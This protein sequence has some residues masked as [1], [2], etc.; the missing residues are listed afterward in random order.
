MGPKPNINSEGYYHSALQC[1]LI[2]VR[3][4]KLEE[5]IA[6]SREMVEA[7]LKIAAEIIRL[8]PKGNDTLPVIRDLFL[9]KKYR[10][11]LLKRLE[12]GLVSREYN[13]LRWLLY[14]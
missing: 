10:E 14:E 6:P 12:K 9:D 2:G 5:A 8:V 1:L 7:E 3:R 4:G 11:W 13:E